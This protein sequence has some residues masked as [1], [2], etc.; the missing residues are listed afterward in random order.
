[1]YIIKVLFTIFILLQGLPFAY[2]QHTED[3]LAEPDFTDLDEV[4]KPVKKGAPERRPA[5]V[6]ALAPAVT[7]LSLADNINDFGRF[8]DGG[9]DSNWFIGFNNAWIVKLPP[10]PSGDYAKAFIGAKVGRAKSQSL[11]SPWEKSRIPG[12]VYMAISQSPSFGSEQ[13]FFL[14]DTQDIPAETDPNVHIPGTGRS[15]WFWT[16]V[17]PS[18]VS[19]ER[20]NYLIIWSPTREFRDAARAPILAGLEAP[21]QAGGTE[22]AAW[23]NHSIQGVP[24]RGEGGTLQVPITN[25]RPALAIKL[26]SRG[27]R[28]VKVLDTSVKASEESLLVRGSV[29][30]RDVELAWVETSPDELEWRRVSP[31]LRTPPYLFTLPRSLLP[32]RG[33]YFRVKARDAAAAEGSGAVRFVSGAGVTD[34]Q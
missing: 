1:M 16:E 11:D 12:K 6:G 28:S 29:E 21:S 26:V 30:G 34:G 2:A 17:Q 20:P 4:D 14:A 5:T 19:T 8:A 32:A 23:N 9:S 7:Y 18:Q 3:P 31:Y 27:E 25:I 22:P 13:S 33:A 10:A 15:A 24:P